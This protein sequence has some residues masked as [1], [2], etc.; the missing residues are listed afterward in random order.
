[1]YSRTMQVV[2][3]IT[4]RVLQVVNLIS[5]NRQLLG[6][7]RLLGASVSKRIVD[8]LLLGVVIDCVTIDKYLLCESRKY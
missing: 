2:N 8:K 4:C 6:K 3:L 7:C 5:A 1:M